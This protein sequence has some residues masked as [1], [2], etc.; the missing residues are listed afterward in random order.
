MLTSLVTKNTSVECK[1]HCEYRASKGVDYQTM[2]LFPGCSNMQFELILEL[3][4]ELILMIQV[5][6]HI[7][8]F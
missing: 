5:H 1:L 3:K 7:K 2:P 6:V 4:E 8:G